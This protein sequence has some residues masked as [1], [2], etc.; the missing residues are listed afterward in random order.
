M[1]VL[2]TVHE[3]VH[4]F[5]DPFQDFARPHLSATT[6]PFFM[7]IVENTT[8]RLTMLILKQLPPSLIPAR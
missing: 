5:L 2:A 1:I 8:Q 3:L 4:V 7:N 6:T